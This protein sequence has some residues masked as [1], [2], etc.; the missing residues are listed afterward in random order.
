M[1]EEE[2]EGVFLFSIRRRAVE[3]L[4]GWEWCRFSG[5]IMALEF[6]CHYQIN[7]VEDI[8]KNP[9]CWS[10][11]ASWRVRLG[12]ALLY[13]LLTIHSSWIEFSFSFFLSSSQYAKQPT[14]KPTNL[15]DQ[16]RKMKN[17]SQKNRKNASWIR[18]NEWKI[19]DV[20]YY[21]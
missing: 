16:K 5:G 20:E 13:C 21:L 14:I 19:N 9:C 4:S 11:L 17:I 15:Y 6:P 1:Q 18:W 2:D 10:G 8:V 12:F 3:W 7:Y